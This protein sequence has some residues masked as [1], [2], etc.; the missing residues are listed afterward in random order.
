MLQRAAALSA[1]VTAHDIEAFDRDGAICLRRAFEPR[2][3]ERVA[4]GIETEL[5]APGSGLV[6]QQAA[7]LPGRFVTDYCAA[8]RIPEF[9]DFIINSPAAAIVAAVMASRTAGFLM[10]V[11]WIKQPGT[12]KPT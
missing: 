6:E 2:W 4:A 11:L 1:P 3:I 5:A 10:D 7:G 12:A 9:Q 8:Q